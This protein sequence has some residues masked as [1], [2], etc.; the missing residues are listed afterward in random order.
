MIPI[1]RLVFP[2]VDS[3]FPSTSGASTEFLIDVE[4]GLTFMTPFPVYTTIGFPEENPEG[5][6]EG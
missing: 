2:S 4:K 1:I 3:P 5:S 6:K